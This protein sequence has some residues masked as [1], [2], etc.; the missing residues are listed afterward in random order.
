MFTGSW[1][2]SYMQS[3]VCSP[4]IQN[5]L[6]TEVLFCF[7]MDTRCRFLLVVVLGLVKGDIDEVRFNQLSIGQQIAG[8]SGKGFT[9]KSH[10]Q[11]A[12]R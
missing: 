2:V 6:L 11:C 8:N 9:A 3:F 4:W 1:G 5:V 12:N 10:L 7:N